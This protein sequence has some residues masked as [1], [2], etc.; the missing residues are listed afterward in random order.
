MPSERQDEIALQRIVDA[1][2]REARDAMF[3]GWRMPRKS[4]VA[5]LAGVSPSTVTHR[6]AEV[7]DAEFAA[8][9]RILEDRVLAEA[10]NMAREGVELTMSGLAERVGITIRPLTIQGRSDVPGLYGKVL[11]LWRA[12]KPVALTPA[13]SKGNPLRRCRCGCTNY[14]EGRQLVHSGYLPECWAEVLESRRIDE[15]NKVLLRRELRQRQSA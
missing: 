7:V 5:K 12:A 11:E 13:K 3:D 9:A 2:K 6:W 10:R 14:T 8:V 1:A 15:R 4:N